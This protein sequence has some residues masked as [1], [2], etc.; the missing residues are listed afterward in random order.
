M[1]AGLPYDAEVEYLESTGTQWIDTLIPMQTIRYSSS[2]ELKG[3]F[4][5]WTSG[6]PVIAG[7]K[8]VDDF[9]LCGIHANIDTVYARVNTKL[10]WR[11]WNNT[12][13]LLNKIF[14]VSVSA[15]GSFVF[16]LG[17]VS[18]PPIALDETLCTS[19]E[20]GNLSL[21]SY[22][23]C[24]RP[25]TGRIYSVKVILQ[26]ET[27]YDAIPVRF[28]N[29]NGQSEGAMYDRVSRKLF[30]NAGTGSFTI[31]PDVATPVM[32][33]HFF[34]SQIKTAKDYVQN[35]L[36]AMW[37]GIEN[38]GYGQHDDNATSWADLTG[39]GANWLLKDSHTPEVFEV[40]SD[41]VKILSE[42]NYGGR[43]YCS[44]SWTSV[45]DLV[46]CEIVFDADN[47]DMTTI[48][49]ARR[50]VGFMA[51]G[52]GIR[53]IWFQSGFVNCG[54]QQYPCAAITQGVYSMSF[55]FGVQRAMLNGAFF[56]STRKGL[57]WI[58]MLG[59]S[60]SG[61]GYGDAYCA[62]GAKIKALRVYGRSLS[63][64]ERL[65]NYAIDKAR[66]NL[67]SSS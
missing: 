24:V 28:T 19:S 32:G 6:F 8:R 15:G 55:D 2:I 66:F 23:D 3:M 5:S 57:G 26:G 38:V 61:Y 25:T 52:T 56:E 30:R 11:G 4:L 29:S 54:F 67:P 9:C 46:S 14:N 31:G 65:A 47:V 50:V 40:G 33:L 18:Y 63:D 59:P 36:I 51:S 12:P 44:P 7:G 37:D 34:K 49:N 1:I 35:G 20:T 53:S 21:F 13:G 42:I 16:T 43:G 45:D 64:A 27:I 41:Y 17:D 39:G 62:V 58:G 48:T 10:V 22:E 60:I